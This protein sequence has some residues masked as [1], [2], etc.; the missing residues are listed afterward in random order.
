VVDDR[1]DEGHLHRTLT[2]QDATHLIQTDRKNDVLRSPTAFSFPADDA[3]DYGA[4]TRAG[5]GFVSATRGREFPASYYPAANDYRIDQWPN[6]RKEWPAYEA[7][8]D[9]LSDVDVD[10]RGGSTR[11]FAYCYVG[12]GGA[13][14][15]DSE[16]GERSK[17]IIGHVDAQ[18]IV[19]KRK[20]SGPYDRPSVIIERDEYMLLFFRIYL[21][22]TRGDV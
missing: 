10:F 4:P 7:S 8:R 6:D 1:V 16:R 9:N 14:D 11:G 12:A 21:E 17:R 15:A 3:A 2:P 13:T 22:S 5:G 18:A 19:S 20:P